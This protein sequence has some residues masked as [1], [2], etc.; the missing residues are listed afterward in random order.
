MENAFLSIMI[1]H[2]LE[3]NETSQFRKV[4]DVVV[5]QINVFS[6]FPDDISFFVARK[7]NQSILAIEKLRF[8]KL[9]FSDR[10]GGKSAFT[11]PKPSLE[12]RH[13]KGLQKHMT[14]GQQSPADPKSDTKRKRKSVRGDSSSLK[15]EKM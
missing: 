3:K 6:I 10:S 15:C 1:N 8:Y 13:Q 12:L 11:E 14:P 5:R 2:R 9:K 4:R 7:C